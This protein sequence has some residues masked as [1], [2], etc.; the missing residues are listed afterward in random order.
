[1]RKEPVII[2]SSFDLLFGTLILLQVK[3]LLNL[4]EMRVKGNFY[5]FHFHSYS[6]FQNLFLFFFVHLFYIYRLLLEAL[7][8]LEV[9][10]THP[11][12]KKTDGNHIF[13]NFVR[14]H[15]MFSRIL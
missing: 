14:A 10:F 15:H 7:D 3:P 8:E 12:A 6:I 1:M 2:D 9:A 5:Y 11:Q 4:F 13:L